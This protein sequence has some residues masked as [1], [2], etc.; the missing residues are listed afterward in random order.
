[1]L[2]EL[3]LRLR[4]ERLLRGDREVKAQLLSDDPADVARVI[5]SPDI[6]LLLSGRDMKPIWTPPR[7]CPKEG[8]QKMG[9]E[10][11]TTRAK[12][13]NAQEAFVAAVEEALH[14]YGHRGYTGTI[15]EKSEFVMI[16]RIKGLEAERQADMMIEDDDRRISDKWG[17]AGCIEAGEGEYLFF[18][19]ASS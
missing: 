8:P 2:S 7:E 11:F 13:K 4:Q 18:G 3:I 16:P 19:W 15:A 17:P 12:G 9:A 1:M 14:E 6:F 5:T 10:S